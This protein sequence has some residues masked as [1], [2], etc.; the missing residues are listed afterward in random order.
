VLSDRVLGAAHRLDKLFDDAAVSELCSCGAEFGELPL[1]EG[2][3]EV[4][5]AIAVAPT[6]SP[7]VKS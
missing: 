1:V 7:S 6:D 2:R 4:N 5:A 3:L